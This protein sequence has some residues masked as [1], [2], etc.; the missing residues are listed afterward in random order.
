[1]LINQ[2]KEVLQNNSNISFAYLFGSYADETFT[3]RSDVDVAVYFKDYDFNKHL[4]LM[5][6]ISKI[7]QK[8]TDLVVLNKAKNL[9]LLE[10]IISK[11][12]LLKDSEKRIDFELR[13]H[14]EYLDYIEFKKRIDAMLDRDKEKKLCLNPNL[15][16]EDI[17]T[18]I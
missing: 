2:L 7:T 11:G 13:K 9:Y 6:K 3:D 10:D 4:E 16:L 15:P 1:M 12:I 5:S 18:Y 14:H 8:D 17:I